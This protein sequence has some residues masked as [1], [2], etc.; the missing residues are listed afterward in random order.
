MIVVWVFGCPALVV[1]IIFKNRKRLHEPEFQ[2]Y[3]IVLYQGFKSDKFYW[4]I[5]NTL[6]KV[7]VV[8]INVFL[9]RFES[10]YKGVTAIILLLFMIRIQMRLQPYKLSANNELELLSFS[11][12]FII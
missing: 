4:E 3:F 2:R 12:K 8:S 11:C 1:Y 6:R 7:I 10:F 9:S 5:V